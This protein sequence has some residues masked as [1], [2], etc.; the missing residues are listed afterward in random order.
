MS[1]C[2]NEEDRFMAHIDS[3]VDKYYFAYSFNWPYF[4]YA[5]K[6]NFIHV[7]NA[8]TPSFIQRYELPDNEVRVLETTL[9]DSKDLFILTET[10]QNIYNIYQIDL[11]AS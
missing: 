1:K 8:F 4:A 3:N 10:Y 6:I 5:N 9:T 7:M 2:H 11:D